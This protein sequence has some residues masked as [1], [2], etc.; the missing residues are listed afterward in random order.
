MH[1][2][3][4]ESIKAEL[5]R[6]VS[7]ADLREIKYNVGQFHLIHLLGFKMRI[8]RRR[9]RAADLRVGLGAFGMA[10]LMSVA[11]ALDRSLIYSFVE[12]SPIFSIITAV[13]LIAAARRQIRLSDWY[14]L[15][16]MMS[17]IITA[18]LLFPALM[19]DPG[20]IN[21]F[22]AAGIVFS[23]SLVIFLN[24]STCFYVI[25]ANRWLPTLR[26]F[27]EIGV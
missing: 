10:A 13:G 14:M 2:L 27:H 20:Q 18:A 19:V 11:F 25:K 3:E 7:I 8:E 5:E 24:I 6:I 17:Y 9:L 21:S 15:F 22:L 12:T 1:S 16:Y 26:Q 4:Q 23:L